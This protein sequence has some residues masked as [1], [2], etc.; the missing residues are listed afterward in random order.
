L[1]LLGAGFLSFLRAP[2]D[3]DHYLFLAFAALAAGGGVGLLV[4]RDPV[5][6]ALGF[7]TTILSTCGLFFL[8]SASFLGAA[9][10]IVYAGATI[11]VFLF[12]LMYAQQSDL[13]YYDVRLTA[14]LLSVL[15]ACAFTAVLV[16]VIQTPTKPRKDRP[17]YRAASAAA[18]GEFP[19][20]VAGLGR[21]LF[22]DYLFAVELA[23]ALLTI[24]AIGAI[25]ASSQ[26]P[27][28]SHSPDDSKET[29]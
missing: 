8:Q 14:P 18:E 6:A 15:L 29:R 17:Q 28:P 9:T 3:L 13:T 11:I 23:G 20:K 21:S 25:A 5:H 24:A 7:A 27:L 22:S 19:S 16:H 4:F 26:S 2:F 10:L 12:V 1:L